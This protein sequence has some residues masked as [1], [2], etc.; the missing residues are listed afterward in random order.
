MHVCTNACASVRARVCSPV[1]GEQAAELDHPLR[2]RTCE[3]KHS[4]R[5]LPVGAPT[6][7]APIVAV[8]TSTARAPLFAGAIVLVVFVLVVVLVLVLVALAL[9]SPLVF[10]F[11]AALGTLVTVAVT[12]GR[13]EDGVAVRPAKQVAAR[14]SPPGYQSAPF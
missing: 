10:V 4:S 13:R 7:Q 6:R 9:A 11:V 3:K 5:P 2:R 14:R 8:R 1:V 12:R